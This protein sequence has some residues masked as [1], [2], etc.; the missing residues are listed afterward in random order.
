MYLA[1]ELIGLADPFIVTSEYAAEVA[2]LDARP[3]DR[4]R[5]VVCPYA[6]PAPV[7]RPAGR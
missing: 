7:A 3:E 6:Y 5:V 2:R 1:R 4:G